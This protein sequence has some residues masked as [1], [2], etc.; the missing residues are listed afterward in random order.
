MTKFPTSQHA[1]QLIGPDKLAL[2]T[3]KPVPTPGPHEIL[4]QVEA[5]GLCFSDLKLLKQFDSHPR[6]SDVVSGIDQDILAS[7]QSYVPNDKPVVPGHEAVCHIVAVG[8]Q[9]EHHQVGER[10][11]VQTDYRQ[12]RIFVVT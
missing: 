5:V 12:T 6:K 1:V 4:L 7:I 11:L 8:D 10:C 2:N 3:S 9:V